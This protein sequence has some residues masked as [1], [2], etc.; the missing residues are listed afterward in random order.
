MPRKSTFARFFTAASH[1]NHTALSTRPL[2]YFI[3]TVPA[4]TLMMNRLQLQGFFPRQVFPKA[5]KSMET[6][7]H[8]DG[9]DLQAMKHTPVQ[10]LRKPLTFSFPGK[11]FFDIPQSY[12]SLIPV[13][14]TYVTTI[15]DVLGDQLANR[16]YDPK[17]KL[18]ENTSER[19]HALE[20]LVITHQLRAWEKNKWAGLAL[21]HDIARSTMADIHHGDRFH[22]LEA[23]QILAPQGYSQEMA[24]R[25]PFLHAF[26]K[27]MWS[28]YSKEYRSELLSPY[29][30]SSLLCQQQDAA[31]LMQ[32]LDELYYSPDAKKQAEQSEQLLTLVVRMMML[33]L[34]DDSAKV[35]MPEIEHR[36]TST[37]LK[38]LITEQTV[39]HMQ[40]LSPEYFPQYQDLLKEALLLL[41]RTKMSSDYPERYQ[42]IPDEDSL[43]SSRC[44]YYL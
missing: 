33:R 34:V 37:Q 26:A 25:F 31:V 19:G 21:Q 18:S 39:A 2:Q 3:N 24:T 6:Y 35:V 43:L 32:Q 29:S 38:Q 10:L 1:Y 36:V 17:E 15:V 27:G 7:L 30:A 8:E 42:P 44:G 23:D 5:P 40:T 11:T 14:D 4:P 20:A 41:R 16:P 12:Q 9:F 28:N 22:H 13:L